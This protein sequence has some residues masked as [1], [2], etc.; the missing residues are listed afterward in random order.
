MRL[1]FIYI[2]VAAFAGVG[3]VTSFEGNYRVAAATI[4]LAGANGLLLL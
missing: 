2:A 4:M 3:I 1:F